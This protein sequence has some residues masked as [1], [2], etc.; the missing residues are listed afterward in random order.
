MCVPNG[1]DV[2]SSPGVTRTSPLRVRPP[3]WPV[4]QAV[5][6]AQ[7]KICSLRLP[8]SRAVFLH[9][10]GDAL[11]R[12]PFS[13]CFRKERQ[14]TIAKFLFLKGRSFCLGNQCIFKRVYTPVGRLGCLGERLPFVEPVA[15]QVFSIQHEDQA[16]S[17]QH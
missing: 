15:G 3:N 8:F 14:L 7:C 13:P 2:L 6:Q 12:K 1:I 9:L 11:T 5:F 10:V 4:C 17:V 16:S